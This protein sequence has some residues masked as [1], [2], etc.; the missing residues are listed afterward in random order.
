MAIDRLRSPFNNLLTVAGGDVGPSAYIDSQVGGLTP[1][2]FVANG[3]AE[4][5]TGVTYRCHVFE[6]DPAQGYSVTFNRAGNIDLLL[7]AGGGGGGGNNGTAHFGS[8]GGGAGG[9][10]LYYGYGV[11]ATTYAIYVGKFGQGNSY[12]NQYPNGEDSTFG[13]LTAVGGGK[14][15]SGYTGG[16]AATSGGSGGGGGT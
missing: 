10:L 15:A 6:Y 1:F 7:L 2:T 14:G 9:L 11:T 13:A 3:E 8:G 12:Y 5:I 4:T 16:P